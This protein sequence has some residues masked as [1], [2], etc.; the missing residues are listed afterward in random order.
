MGNGILNIYRTT[1]FTGVTIWA[2][3]HTGDPGSAGTTSP[4]AVVTRNQVTFAAAANLSMTLST[5]SS[6]TMTTTETISHI[7]MWDASTGGNFM[8][9][10]TLTAAQ[11]VVNTNTLTLTTLTLS[12]T[13]AAA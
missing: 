4:S 8:Q 11:S 7:S 5:V 6:W 13:P 3:L 10:A 1:T 2:K 12:Y 9:S